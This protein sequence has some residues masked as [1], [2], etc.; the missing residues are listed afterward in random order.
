MEWRKST[1]SVD[2]GNCVEVAS[3]GAVLIRDTQDR[4]GAALA[5][6]A[7]AWRAFTAK[8]RSSQA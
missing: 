3:A 8:V 1:H 6:P 2:N 4:E 5:V 7:R